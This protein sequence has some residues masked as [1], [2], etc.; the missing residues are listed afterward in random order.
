[1]ARPLGPVRVGGIM[2]H[3]GD[4]IVGDVDD[5]VVMRK[6]PAGEVLKMAQDIDARAFELVKL[7]GHGRI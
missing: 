6:A 2:L 5:V 7:V 4:R 3:G 1:M